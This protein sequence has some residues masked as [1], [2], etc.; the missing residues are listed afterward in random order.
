[1][2]RIPFPTESYQHPSK[3]LSTKFLQNFMAEKAPD[4]ARSQVALVPTPG[5]SVNRLVG[6][7]PIHAMN[8]DLPGR[9]YVVSGTH[10]YRLIP[11]IGSAPDFTVEDLGDI[12][13][14]ATDVIPA[15][16]AMYTIACGA[17]AAVVCVP[18][19][20]FTCSH[21][22]GSSLNQISGD[23]WP[24][25]QSV[26]F[27]DGYHIFVSYENSARFFI[28]HLLDPSNFDALDFAYTDALPNVL[29]RVFPYRTD[30]WMMGEAGVEI[31]YA[32]GASGLETTP[33]T[34]FFPYRR[35]AGGVI[36][37]AMA[38]PQSVAAGDASIFWLAHNQVV[39]KTNGYQ[40]VRVS[41]HAVE[42][43][44]RELNPYDLV[45]AFTY[46]EVGHVL[47]VMNWRT[48]TLVYDCA[49]KQ[50]HDRASD[51]GRWRANATVHPGTMLWFGDVQ[52]G[53]IFT[54]QV[55]S[56]LAGLEDITPI[57]RQIVF[58]P[59][60]AG[61][62]RAFCA[63]VEVE[64]ESGDGRL[65]DGT[66][67]LDWS[68]DGGYSWHGGPRVMT[69][70]LVEYNRRQRVFTTRLGSFRQRVFRLTLSGAAT[71]YAVDAEITTGA[72]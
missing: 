13:T 63:R 68:D 33:G 60:W 12:G 71:I 30:L 6:A 7:G 5:L 15:Y 52:S 18:P 59:L 34:S 1:M 38:S 19:N 26:A 24:G 16:D 22:P 49:T 21:D 66:V 58:P 46:T 20:A 48:R 42:E 43:I 35:R 28:S 17:T 51:G 69:A 4:D 39:Y 57:S 72:S 56:P 2:R 54:S 62:S 47:Y 11:Q 29:R 55:N 40:A 32:A 67:T 41:T 14:P 45:S 8:D 44:I 36:P 31:W 27:H 9:V 70:K 23:T 50:W 25:A 61:A 65:E 53:A 64:M 10:F 3:P 37:F